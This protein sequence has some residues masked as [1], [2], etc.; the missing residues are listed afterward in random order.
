VFRRY[1]IRKD[2]PL[3]ESYCLVCNSFVAASHAE[4]NLT[5]MELLHALTCRT[6][7]EDTTEEIKEK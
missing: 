6:S 4:L 5:T 3:I 2:P 1:Q 7:E